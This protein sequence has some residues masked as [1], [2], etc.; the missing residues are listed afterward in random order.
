M[1]GIHCTYFVQSGDLPK[2]RCFVR[3]HNVEHRYYH[4]LWETSSSF[5]KKL[6]FERE[7]KLL[8]EYEKD[9]ANKATFWTV[10]EHDLQVFHEELGYPGV[11]Y[12]PLFM[13]EYRPEYDGRMGSFCLYHGNL[14]VPENE[15]AATWLLENIFADLEI[16]FVVAGKNPSPKLEKLAHKKMHTCL[17]ANPLEKEMQEMIRM[18]QVNI[19]PSFNN[20]GIKLKLVNA[21]YMGKHCIVNNAGV[22]GTGLEGCCTIANTTA[23]MKAAVAAKFETP[24]E[25]SDFNN[26]VGTLNHLF[27]NRKNA[28]QMINWIFNGEPTRPGLRP[29]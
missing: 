29:R 27:D 20:T 11:D 21:L 2:E 22:E 23:D 17:V 6:Y 28:S 18:A 1:E 25:E 14:S 26:R 8:Y 4:Q 19:L 13:P 10:C 9:L 12:L 16:P 3:L 24:F 7:S 15:Y 5:F